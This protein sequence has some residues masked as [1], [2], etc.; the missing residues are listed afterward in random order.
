MAWL[1]LEWKCAWISEIDKFPCAVLAHHYPDVSNLGDVTNVE[2]SKQRRPDVI[3][4]GS[5]CQSFSVA[6]KRLGMGDP[7]GNLALEYL[8][9]V[10][11]LRPEWFV[12]EN[13]PGLLS[14][15][16]GRDFGA[17][18]GEVAKLG[19]GWA[20]RILDAKY[21]GVPQRRRRVFVVGHS[22]GDWRRCAAVLFEP[23]SMRGDT[24]PGRKKR[25]DITQAVTGRLGG[26]GP[27]DN[28]AQGGFY[29]TTYGGNNT[30]GPIDKAACLNAHGGGS[31][32]MD[33]ESETFVCYENHGQD[34]RIKEITGAA[35]QLNAKAGTGGNNLPIVFQSKSSSS[36]SMNQSEKTPAIDVGKSDGMEVMVHWTQGGGE[37]EDGLLGS[38]RA[39]PEHNWQ[40]IRQDYAVRRLTPV[41]CE[42]LQGFPDHYTRIPYRNKSVDQCPP[43]ARD[44]RLSETAWPFR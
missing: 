35:P 1:P 36:K 27:G 6:G 42:R 14:S 19:Y 26:G 15:G 11:I 9:V 28:K 30:A 4:G 20:W 3:I 17:F 7:R 33:F 38:L 32:R 40:F 29:G 25:T 39:D 18:L 2:W 31:R 13:V 23:E 44:T 43:T 37:V 10:S 21:F 34:S 5:P 41:E 12:F 24:A 16:R 22:S 8:R